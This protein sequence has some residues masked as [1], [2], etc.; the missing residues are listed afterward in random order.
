MDEYTGGL[1]LPPC[2]PPP[3]PPP[4]PFAA[5]GDATIVMTIAATVVIVMPYC[6]SSRSTLPS[7]LRSKG[8][9][10]SDGMT[11]LVFATEEE[12]S[13]LGADDFWIAVVRRVTIEGFE[14]MNDDAV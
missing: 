5:A 2:P 12:V 1:L 10:R 13:S 8:C 4:P 6:A 14:W 11:A 3:P 7:L 9:L